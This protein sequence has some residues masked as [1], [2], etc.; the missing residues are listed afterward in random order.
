MSGDDDMLCIPAASQSILHASLSRLVGCLPSGQATI[1]KI[2]YVK[3]KD[4]EMDTPAMPPRIMQLIRV[5]S[6]I[7]RGLRQLL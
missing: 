7:V 5:S 4:T 3:T 2:N 1:L 6:F